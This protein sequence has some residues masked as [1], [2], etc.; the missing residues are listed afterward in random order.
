VELPPWSAG[1]PY[2]FITQMRQMLES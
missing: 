1:N 2:F